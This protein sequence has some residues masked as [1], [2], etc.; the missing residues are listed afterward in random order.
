MQLIT[1]YFHLDFSTFWTCFLAYWH[2][3]WTEKKLELVELFAMV[4]CDKKE[5]NGCFETF[6]RL[7]GAAGRVEV[8]LG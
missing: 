6:T 8:G 2:I 3:I 7:A 1:F 4:A 5:K